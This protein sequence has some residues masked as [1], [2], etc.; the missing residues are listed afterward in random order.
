LPENKQGNMENGSIELQEKTLQ[1]NSKDTAG[2]F[3]AIACSSDEGA[4]F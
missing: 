1:R 3:A 4:S 2:L